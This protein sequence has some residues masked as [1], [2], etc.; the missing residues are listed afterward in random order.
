MLQTAAVIIAVAI[1]MLSNNARKRSLNHGKVSQ[2]VRQI[3]ISWPPAV[4]P[5]VLSLPAQQNQQP[6][7]PAKQRPN[8]PPDRHSI[9]VSVLPII[10]EECDRELQA[11]LLRMLPGMVMTGLHMCYSSCWIYFVALE[12]LMSLNT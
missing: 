12:G 4:S 2:T 7:S 11:A 9:R 1:L 3:T 10:S 6:E 5:S 8:L